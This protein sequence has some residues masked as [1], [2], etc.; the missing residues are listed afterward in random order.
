M[1]VAFLDASV[2]YPA[3]TRSVLLYVALTGSYRARWSDAVQDEWMRALLR[4]RPDIDANRIAR[5]RALM[6]AR[7]FDAVVAGYD[8]LIAPLSLPDPDD[9][10]VLAAAIHGGA[11]VIVTLNLKDFP[12]SALAPH[13]ITALHPDHFLR[14]LL[15]ADSQ[16]VV[17]AFAADRASLLNPPMT[18]DQ[19]LAA[20]ERNGLVS[21]A[22]ALRLIVG[23]LCGQ[24]QRMLSGVT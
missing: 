5:T 6:D 21:T 16:S 10:H 15:D 20:L 18:V 3:M 19:Y 2:L 9:R 24:W 8:A 11:S 23:G 22:A 14:A 1:T 17:T 4:N 13:N 7:I 12:A